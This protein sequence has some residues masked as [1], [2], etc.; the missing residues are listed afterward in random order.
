MLNGTD[1]SAKSKFVE[2]SVHEDLKV[3]FTQGVSSVTEEKNRF[4]NPKV[5]ISTEYKPADGSDAS[6][7]LINNDSDRELIVLIHEVKLGFVFYSNSENE[8]LAIK[9]NEMRALLKG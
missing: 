7:T 6:I 2:D 1:L 5:V 9:F 4:I 8:N 3:L